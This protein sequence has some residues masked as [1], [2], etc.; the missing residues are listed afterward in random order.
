MC[1]TSAPL[2]QLV[3]QDHRGW[4]IL[5]VAARAQET[6]LV[7]EMW[8]NVDVDGCGHYKRLSILQQLEPLTVYVN[9]DYNGMDEWEINGKRLMV[10]TPARSAGASTEQPEVQ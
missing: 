9:P 2:I 3:G 6:D 4:K 10:G 5:H 7:V 8:V 1:S